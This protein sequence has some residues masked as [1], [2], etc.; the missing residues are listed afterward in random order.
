MLRNTLLLLALALIG[1]GQGWGTGTTYYFKATAKANPTGA[2]KVYA[3]TSDKEPESSAYEENYSTG[4]IAGEENATTK[5]FY[6]FAQPATGY[7]LTNWTLSDGS[8]AGIG[9]PLKV[10]ITGNATSSDTPAEK[11]YTANFEKIGALTVESAE[12]TLGAASLDKTSNEIGDEV[13]LKADPVNSFLPNIFVGWSKGDDATIISKEAVLKITVSDDTKGKYVAHFKSTAASTSTEG[14]YGGYYRLYGTNYKKYLWMVGKNYVTTNNNDGFTGAIFI[15]SIICQPNSS[16]FFSTTSAASEEYLSYPGSIIFVSGKSSDEGL[17]DV[18]FEAQ[19]MDAK[20]IMKSAGYS[21]TILGRLMDMGTVKFY[22]NLMGER[23]LKDGNQYG[24]RVG[25]SAIIC[26]GDGENNYQLQPITEDLINIYYFGAKPNK[27]VGDKYYTTMYTAFPYKCHDGV[28]AYIVDDVTDGVAHMTEIA[29][30]EVPSKT[31]VILECSGPTPK[32]NRLVPMLTEPT[33]DLSNNLLKG[34]I[35]LDNDTQ[36]ARGATGWT[37]DY[38]TAFDSTT[39]RVLSV[40][41]DGK[42]VLSTKNDAVSRL[43]TNPTGKYLAT[44][45]AYL[46]VATGTPATIYFEKS[47]PTAVETTLSGL[48]KSGTVGTTYKVT[49]NSL[50]AVTQF[51][52]QN[53]DPYLVVTDGDQSVKNYVSDMTGERF[54]I[55]KKNQKEYTQT[56]WLLVK[57]ASE[58]QSKCDGLAL[59]SVT[60]KL[61]D[62]ANPTIEATEVVASNAAAPVA[63]NFYCPINFMTAVGSNQVK[64]DNAQSK[65]YFFMTPKPAEYAIITYAAYGSDG[66]IYIPAK[67]EDSKINGQEFEGGVT[68]N[69]DYNETGPVAMSTNSDGGYSFY[70]IVKANATQPSSSARRVTANTKGGVSSYFTV[71]P[72]NLTEPVTAVTD[73]ETA[74]A[75]QSVA[76]YNVAGQQSPVPFSGI[77]IVR[78]TYTDG[79]TRVAKVIR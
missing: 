78:T 40:N 6:L 62:A 54:D 24:G 55:E 7:T 12:P 27:K 1:T 20:S 33:I 22:A 68:L 58:D 31:A 44:N 37:E 57:C 34:V 8:F 39:M 19:G 59:T 30:G 29:N 70:A 35:D 60:G 23:Y 26:G 56:N 61:I 5:T 11:S 43:S 77:N 66:N 15:N 9:S 42:L 2:G 14:Y 50:K 16:Q 76:Y 46:P 74:K 64:G 28:K 72:V 41:A 3:S 69:W 48:A 21:N 49:G 52:A 67:S 63:P 65:T 53:G 36:H 32:E 79:S 45:S 47:A 75:V 18:N 38:R 25:T 51:K 13:T 4:S 73:V 71:Y 17:T 10:T